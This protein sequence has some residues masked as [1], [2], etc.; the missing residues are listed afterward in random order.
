MDI[1]TI[2][3]FIVVVVCYIMFYACSK[4]IWSKKS[5]L[6]VLY[7]RPVRVSAFLH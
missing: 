4:S 2:C 5:L 1:P 6:G 3:G 7:A